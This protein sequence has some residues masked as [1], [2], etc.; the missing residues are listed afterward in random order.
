M[1][2]S[3][4]PSSCRP[5]VHRWGCSRRYQREEQPRWEQKNRLTRLSPSA[6]MGRQCLRVKG[7]GESRVLVHPRWL[8]LSKVIESHINTAVTVSY[9]SNVQSFTYSWAYILKQMS[10]FLFS[11]RPLSV[12]HMD[13]FTWHINGAYYQV[14]TCHKTM[15]DDLVRN[16]GCLS[17]LSATLGCQQDGF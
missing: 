7:Q 13:I 17:S 16:N 1:S 5:H 12:E 6:Q 15:P 2:Q 10:T 4:A 3:S 8:L 11:S 14:C 9:I